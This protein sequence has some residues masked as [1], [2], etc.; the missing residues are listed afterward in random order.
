ME[1]EMQVKVT[2]Y[3]EEQW[4]K[5]W[6]S[7]NLIQCIAFL[8]EKLRLVPKEYQDSAQITIEGIRDFENDPIAEIEIFYLRPLT[9]EETAKMKAREEEDARAIRKHEL[10][11]LKQ[12]TEKYRG[13]NTM[14]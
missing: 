8:N 10:E 3:K 6:P 5:D 14:E 2:G 1:T 11:M 12:L 13:N 4:S 7:E 9:K